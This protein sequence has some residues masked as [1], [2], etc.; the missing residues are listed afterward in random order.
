MMCCQLPPLLSPTATSAASPIRACRR[1]ARGLRLRLSR[2]RV[3]ASARPAQPRG[4]P[5][6][7]S[8]ATVGVNAKLVLPETDKAYWNGRYQDG[9]PYF[10]LN[11]IELCL[12]WL[13]DVLGVPVCPALLAH[14]ASRRPN[15]P[16]RR[17]PGPDQGRHQLRRCT[18]MS[19]SA[20]TRRCA[21]VAAEYVLACDPPAGGWRDC[22]RSA[23]VCGHLGTPSHRPQHPATGHTTPAAQNPRPLLAPCWISP[24]PTSSTLY[25]QIAHACTHRARVNSHLHLC[26]VQVESPHK[27]SMIFIWRGRRR[28]RGSRWRCRGG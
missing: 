5:V 23:D 9:C 25:K 7:A 28:A 1:T 2:D 8:S 16:R 27:S 3:P 13:D 18:R 10:R 15:L 21:D 4:L 17:H 22:S 14:P 11:S 20:A 12:Q 24:S 26:N 19:P 6:R